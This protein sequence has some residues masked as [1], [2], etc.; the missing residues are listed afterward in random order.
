M[1]WIVKFS[2][3]NICSKMYSR[4]DELGTILVHHRVGKFNIIVF[5]GA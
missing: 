2:N 4:N 5:P 3:I 1:C